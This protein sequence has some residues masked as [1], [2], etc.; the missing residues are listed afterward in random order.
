MKRCIY[1]RNGVKLMPYFDDAEL[2]GL[3]LDLYLADEQGRIGRL[4]TLGYCVY[5]AL[6]TQTVHS[7]VNYRFHNFVEKRGGYAE[8]FQVLSDPVPELTKKR[9]ESG[10]RDRFLLF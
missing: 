7:T 6:L 10:C 5:P 3:D 1:G 4:A 2:S 9:Y 8:L